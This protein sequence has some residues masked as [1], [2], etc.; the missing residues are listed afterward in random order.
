MK[1]DQGMDT[2][3]YC[4]QSEV[5]IEDKSFNQIFDE[6][7]QAGSKDL[8]YALDNFDSLNWQAQTEAN[9]TYANK[10]EKREL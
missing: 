5:Q 8:M 2:G 7:A 6:L 1:M 9:V 3:D 10:L 4:I